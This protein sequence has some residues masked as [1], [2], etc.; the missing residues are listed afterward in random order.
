MAAGASVDMKFAGASV[1]WDAVAVGILAANFAPPHLE[2]GH[3]D[4]DD[5]ELAQLPLGALQRPDA[6]PGVRRPLKEQAAVATWFERCGDFEIV[7]LGRGVGFEPLLA[8]E[9]EDFA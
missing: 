2:T 9:D 1:R 7:K 6:V 8:I 3:V 4:G 5:E